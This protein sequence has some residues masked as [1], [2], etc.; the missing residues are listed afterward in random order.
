[1][2]DSARTTLHA[3][4]KPQRVATAFVIDRDGTI[5]EAFD[6]AAWA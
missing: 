2:C 1:V 5:F 3:G 4:G 6:L